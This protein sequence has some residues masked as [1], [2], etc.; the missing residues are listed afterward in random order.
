M[1]ATL[2]P[3][4]TLTAPAWGSAGCGATDLDA[5]LAAGFAAWGCRG[6]WVAPN[7]HAR[8]G[9]P[10]SRPA[11]DLLG[12]RQD[13]TVV[14]EALRGRFRP[15]LDAAVA[16]L[17]ERIGTYDYD[18]REDLLV[19]APVVVGGHRADLRV[20]VCYGY[21]YGVAVFRDLTPAEAA[22]AAEAERLKA[23]AEDAKRAAARAKRA[24]SRNRRLPPSG[25]TP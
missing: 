11:L 25:V 12:D 3:P 9:S 16:A 17:R 18:S 6:I 20:R 23:E 13:C 15:T 24:A 10:A 5:L 14:D 19:V 22:E 4:A 21:V 2:A 7:W 8:K 1:N